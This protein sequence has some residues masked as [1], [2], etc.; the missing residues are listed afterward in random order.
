M[1]K[2]HKTLTIEKWN[3]LPFL[4]MMANVGSE[5]ERTLSWLEK[6][7]EEY[8]QQAFFRSLD[9]FDL[10]L[11]SDIT[12]SQKKETARCREVWA[13]FIFGENEYKSDNE[14]FRKYFMWLT[15]LYKVR[16]KA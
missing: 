4:E 1:T 12:F 2:F 8:S 11:N 6:G 13:D 10:T 16:T 14:L 5:V 9:L 7:N 3:K 15:V